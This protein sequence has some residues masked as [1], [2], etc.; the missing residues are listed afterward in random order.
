MHLI[1]IPKLTNIRGRKLFFLKKDINPE[2]QHEQKSQQQKKQNK[3]NKNPAT[4]KR[5]LEKLQAKKTLFELRKS[6]VA[7]PVMRSLPETQKAPY[8]ERTN[9]QDLSHT[10]RLP[11]FICQA[12]TEVIPI[13]DSASQAKFWLTIP[14]SQFQY[15][16]GSEHIVMLLVWRNRGKK[17]ENEMISHCFPFITLQ[18]LRFKGNPRRKARDS[19][20]DIIQNIDCYSEPVI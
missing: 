6:K 3:A 18:T 5:K 14:L 19:S 17:R 13:K 10:Q 7:N 9:S 1:N 2:G 8:K 12:Q 16:K 15:I 11:D 4:I 20:F